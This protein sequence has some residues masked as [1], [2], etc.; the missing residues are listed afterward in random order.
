M[1]LKKKRFSTVA[2]PKLNIQ[3]PEKLLFFNFI[4]RRSRFSRQLFSFP[5]LLQRRFPSKNIQPDD[6]MSLYLDQRAYRITATV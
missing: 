3:D 4:F 2:L 6:K 5:E 1:V